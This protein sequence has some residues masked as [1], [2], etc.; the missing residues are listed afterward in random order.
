MMFGVL[1]FFVFAIN[2][3]CYAKNKK[4]TSSNNDKA[5]ATSVID[6]ASAPASKAAEEPRATAPANKINPKDLGDASVAASLDQR[7]QNRVKRAHHL[8][9]KGANIEFLNSPQGIAFKDQISALEQ[10]I[11]AVYEKYLNIFRE[12]PN[13]EKGKKLYAERDRLVQ[14][15]FRKMEKTE[16]DYENLK[17]TSPVY[18]AMVEKHL[19]G[20]LTQLRGKLRSKSSEE[21]EEEEEMEDNQ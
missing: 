14:S 21:S 17:K 18:R 19:K 15:L 4:N 7:S 9:E 2:I 16:N 3:P 20:E 13:T 11:N 5:D 1:V 10:E 6:A 12:G 8:A